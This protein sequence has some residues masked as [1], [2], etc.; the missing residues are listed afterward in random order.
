MLD[1]FPSEI[2]SLFYLNK[3]FFILLYSIVPVIKDLYYS[4]N[5]AVGFFFLRFVCSKL[6]NCNTL[7]CKDLEVNRI[8]KDIK[9]I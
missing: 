9:Q 1:I 2:L 8:I 5:I 4:F 3:I 6:K 7:L